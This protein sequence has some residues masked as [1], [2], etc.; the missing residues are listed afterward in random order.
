MY[1]I[2]ECG[3]KSSSILLWNLVLTI[4]IDENA[5]LIVAV[6]FRN[7]STSTSRTN[8]WTSWYKLLIFQSLPAMHNSEIYR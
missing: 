2:K 5:H 1:K 3:I 6:E 4:F 8:I 7:V